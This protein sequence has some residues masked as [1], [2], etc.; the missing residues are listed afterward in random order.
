[1]VRKYVKLTIETYSRLAAAK[2][3][4]ESFNDAI[5]RLADE[6]EALR[7]KYPQYIN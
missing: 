7:K 5:I 2:R 1:M 3:E 4:N 6:Y